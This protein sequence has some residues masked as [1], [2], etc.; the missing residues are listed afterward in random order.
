MKEIKKERGRKND[1]KGERSLE[2]KDMKGKKLRRKKK[3]QK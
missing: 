1:R 2:R 3:K